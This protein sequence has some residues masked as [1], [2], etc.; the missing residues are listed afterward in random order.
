MPPEIAKI[1]PTELRHRRRHRSKKKT[2]RPSLRKLERFFLNY[3]LGIIGA[4]L[5]CI[6]LIYIL[7]NYVSYNEI[8]NW[9]RLY[10]I[11][12]PEKTVLPIVGEG[13]MLS[14][15]F[16]GFLYCIGLVPLI[17]TL[18]ISKDKVILKNGLVA[19]GIFSLTCVQVW[20]FQFNSRFGGIFFAGFYSA[21][22]YFSVVQVFLM[23]ISIISKNRFTFSLSTV[24]FFVSIAMIRS[25]FGHLI[26]FF[27]A[28]AILQGI[29]LAFSLKY[30]WRSPFI[31]IVLLSA[32]YLS[33][34]LLRKIIISGDAV[35]VF[36]MLP[37]LFTWVVI[38]IT[39]LAILIPLS[40]RKS[41]RTLWRFLSYFSLGLTIVLITWAM[42]VTGMMPVYPVVTVAAVA[43]L[44]AVAILD[45]RY[46]FLRSRKP[47]YY[48]ICILAAMLPPQLLPASFIF[49][50]PAALAVTFLINVL[51]TRS[52]T[53][54][55]LSVVF[56]LLALVAYGLQWILKIFP[57]LMV[58]SDTGTAV[59]VH[60]ALSGM[61]VASMVYFYVRLS[62]FIV[63]DPVYRQKP[64]QVVPFIGETIVPAVFY[65]S[66]FLV[67]NWLVMGVFP[68][69]RLSMPE[70]GMYTYAYLF[71]YH[72]R[73]ASSSAPVLKTRVTLS[74]MAI[75][76]YPFIVQHDVTLARSAMLE[77]DTVAWLPFIMHYACF[78]LMTGLLLQANGYLAV[79]Y[80]GIKKTH[81]YRRLMIYVLAGYLL[82]SEF[83]H[84]SLLLQGGGGVPAA[85]ILRANRLVPYSIILMAVAVIMLIH[86]LIQKS[87]FLRRVSLGMILL[88]LLK[89]FIL[90]IRGLGTTAI[91]VLL[92]SLG[93]L[94]VGVSWVVPRLRKRET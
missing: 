46:D 18:F 26:P 37:A 24:F 74:L 43:A 85:D 29:V 33:F 4:G 91:I 25:A 47:V 56:L 58:Q 80:H 31:V 9:I 35:P 48:S 86:S 78:A 39:G 69:Y 22:A 8:Q 90:D 23:F 11:P 10:F 21:L 40:A 92:I 61:L 13:S 59:P 53:G 34:Y 93:L 14:T 7:I 60:L 42:Y 57:A 79:M 44:I 50:L 75:V 51:L 28:L 38:S 81:H 20:L 54:Y 72:W 52:R 66:G 36:F 87:R 49:I 15:F 68:G 62:E 17:I 83:D 63:R 70:A 2:Q 3:G 65:A 88:V 27:L 94:L 16:L 89:I 55:R 73:N 41:V 84:L 82:V 32:L 12:R 30:R 45:Q 76:L 77:G 6:G 64:G 67:L 5:M 1:R 19:L 71:V